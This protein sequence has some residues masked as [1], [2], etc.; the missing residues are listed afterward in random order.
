MMKEG[1]MTVFKLI[2]GVIISLLLTQVAIAQDT[3]LVTGATGRTGRL[4]VES[5]LEEGYAVRAMSRSAEKAKSL[6]EGVDGMA[7]DVTKPE[8]LAAVM[9]DISIVISSVGARWPIG[10]NGFEAVDWEGNRALIDE[11]KKAGV[12]QF[13]L[14]SA[15]SAGR[16]GFVYTLSFAPYPWK[17]KSEN[18]LRASGLSYTILAAGGLRDNPA[19]E[20]AIK[21][22]SRPDY[23]SG[24]ISRGDLADVSVAAI[25][26]QNALNKTITIVNEEDVAANKGALDFAPLPLD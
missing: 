17:A 26:N 6:G 13:I 23:V 7:G 20:L 1:S 15:G 8:T 18:Y 2:S 9:K 16:D 12:D 3:V 19:G 24:P 4:I 22:A 5:L 21:L 25:R 10:D 11:A 14:I